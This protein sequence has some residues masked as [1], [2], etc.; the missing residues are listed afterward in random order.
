MDSAS[1]DL[2]ERLIRISKE[3]TAMA[4]EIRGVSR[5]PVF[6]TESAEKVAKRICLDCGRAVPLNERYVRG[7]DAACG[8]VARN[9]IRKGE[10]T[11]SEL[12]SKGLLAPAETGGKKRKQKSSALQKFIDEKAENQIATNLAKKSIRHTHKRNRRLK[13]KT[14]RDNPKSEEKD[15]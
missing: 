2:A 15:A 8:G 1:K 14:D 11:E 9:R 10:F 4:G 7:L 6:P 13:K 5:E 3:L 12:I